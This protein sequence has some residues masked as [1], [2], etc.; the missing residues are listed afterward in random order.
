MKQKFK[1]GD[2]LIGAGKANKYPSTSIGCICQITCIERKDEYGYDSRY[3]G[4][5]GASVNMI[6]HPDEARTSGGDRINLPVYRSFSGFKKISKAK[7]MS[8]LL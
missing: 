5:L 6:W 2:Y 7:A 8:Y 4:K 3:N 1:V